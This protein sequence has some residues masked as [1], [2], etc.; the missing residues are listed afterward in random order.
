MT[1]NDNMPLH[2]VDGKTL[3]N[4][5]IFSECWSSQE[6]KCLNVLQG[7]FIPISQIPIAHLNLKKVKQQSQR[8]L[9]EKEDNQLEK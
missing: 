9:S 8:L 1:K 4:E 3:W 6:R 2:K 7:I 5:L